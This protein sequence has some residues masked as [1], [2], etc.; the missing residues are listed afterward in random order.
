MMRCAAAARLPLLSLLAAAAASEK[1]EVDLAALAQLYEKEHRRL[2]M[3]PPKF[4]D[5]VQDR[6]GPDDGHG[7]DHGHGHGHDHG[8]GHGGNSSHDHHKCVHDK[9]AEKLR[10]PAHAPQSYKYTDAQSRRRARAQGAY[11]NMRIKWHW[12][13]LAQAQSGCS[14]SGGPNSNCYCNAASDVLPDFFGGTVHC[15]PADVFTATT[16]AYLDGILQ[17]ATDWLSAALKVMPVQGNLK[18]SSAICEGIDGSG[19]YC[20]PPLQPY[21]GPSGWS[22]HGV[23]VPWSHFNTGVA[24]ADLVIYATAVPAGGSTWAWAYTCMNDQNN[25]PTA[26]HVNFSPR[27]YNTNVQPGTEEYRTYVAVAI[28]EIMHALGF[29]SW[30]WGG[31]AWTWGW[32][33]DYCMEH[34]SDFWC[35][36]AF[37]E[38]YHMLCRCSPMQQFAE[39]GQTGVNKLTS[40][41]VLDSVRGYSGCATLNGAELEQEGGEG[42]AASHWEKRVFGNEGMTGITLGWHEQEFGATTLALLE[43]TGHYISVASAANKDYAWGR[44]KGCSFWTDK[45]SDITP[46]ASAGPE[47]CFPADP[48]V[49]LP[50]CGFH[51]KGIGRCGVTQHNGALDPEF[52]YFPGRPKYGGYSG[53]GLDY[54]PIFVPWSNTMCTNPG[55]A[56]TGAWADA[57]LGMSRGV[58]SRCFQSDAYYNDDSSTLSWDDKLR[59]FD[60]QCLPGCASYNIILQ[61]PGGGTETLLCTAAGPPTYPS[62]FQTRWRTS[63]STSGAAAVTCWDPAEMCG[64]EARSQLGAACGAASAAPTAVPRSAPTRAPSSSPTTA[65]PTTSPVTSNPTKAPSSSP[66]TAAPTESPVTSSPT[67]APTSSPTTTAPTK[68]PATSSPTTAPALS[69]WDAPSP[70]VALSYKVPSAGGTARRGAPQDLVDDTTDVNC[71]DIP[72]GALELPWMENVTIVFPPGSTSPGGYLNAGRFCRIG[73]STCMPAG[74]QICVTCLSQHCGLHAL[75]YHEPP[76]SSRTNGDLPGTLPNAMWTP[77]GRCAPHFWT[78]ENATCTHPMLALRRVATSGETV[79]VDID[80]SLPAAYFALAVTR[81]L[82]CTDNNLMNETACQQ[83]S[84]TGANTCAWNGTACIE[85]WCPKLPSQGS[86]GGGG[87]AGGPGSGCGLPDISCS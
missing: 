14:N 58:T 9:M 78:T 47:F 27:K 64:E 40:D 33:T 36:P 55:H 53:Q 23:Q 62:G 67:T 29:S 41:R 44:N 26:G 43:D 20:T 45:C 87:A 37:P 60:V 57:D 4:Y 34:G 32:F 48:T 6:R 35:N 66:T 80:P 28:H 76:A 79:C 18:A 17:E 54:C 70:I 25:R 71:S 1:I 30:W 68:S 46:A 12:G 11:D 7:H 10:A 13:G 63:Q 56:W 21:C 75:L 74:A 19:Q 83:Q 39:R 22:D 8:H 42:T 50:G 15:S 5:A 49:T 77:A 86:G 73:N 24:D 52:Q 72:A 3:N 38:Q 69:P 82:S 85:G 51:L 61:V 81:V 59:C 65:A 31:A 2:I 84:A 16:R